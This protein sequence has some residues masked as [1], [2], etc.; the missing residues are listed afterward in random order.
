MARS[1]ACLSCPVSSLALRN[2]AAC[3]SF[4]RCAVASSLVSAAAACAFL[5]ERL[6]M[7]RRAFG[8]LLSRGR[9]L[10][11]EGG[12]FLP[13][14]L[15]RL[16]AVRGFCL[17]ELFCFLARPC[18][19]ASPAPHFRVARRKLAPQCGAPCAF[20]IEHLTMFRRSGGQ[21]LSRSCRLLREGGHFLAFLFEQFRVSGIRPLE[22]LCFLARL[23]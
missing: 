11:R 4:S 13:L 18:A 3:I 6:T 2:C 10:L 23:A 1:V 8:Q 14:L 9:G 5:V 16:C 17:L 19:V 12:R 7:F 15:E 22:L 20:L 21:L